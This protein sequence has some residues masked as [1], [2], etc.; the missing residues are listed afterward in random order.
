MSILL[1]GCTTWTLTKHIEKNLDG[2]CTKMLRAILNKSKKQ[3]P[4]KQ[5]LYGHQPPIF[6]TIQI[7][8]T[9]HAGQYWRSKRELIRDVIQ[10]TSSHGRAIVGRPARTYLLQLCTDTG[11]SLENL[12]EKMD[13]RDEWRE[14]VREIRLNGTTWWLAFWMNCLCLIERLRYL[15]IAE[16]S[17][18]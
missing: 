2:N 11:C 5:P 13:D 9:K 18:K 6:K 4:T 14:R 16:G 17:M 15:L 7:R 3:H 8:R 1:Y 10:W 12:P